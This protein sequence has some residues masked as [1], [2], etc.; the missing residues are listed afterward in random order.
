MP[1]YVIIVF[2][3][4]MA[5]SW[6]LGAKARRRLSQLGNERWEHVIVLGAFAGRKYF[7]P[8]GWRYRNLCFLTAG[9]AF[10][11]AVCLALLSG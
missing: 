6:H 8:E 4:G 3:G 11:I 7:T 5:L 2:L 1:W 9:A 10:L